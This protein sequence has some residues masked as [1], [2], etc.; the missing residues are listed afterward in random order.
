MHL[1]LYTMN[2]KMSSLLK[3]MN[4]TFSFIVRQTRDAPNFYRFLKASVAR[5][6]H[7]LVDHTKFSSSRNEFPLGIFY[8]TVSD[9]K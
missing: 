2:T 3:E 1:S 8:T 5:F 4:D 6:A 9:V 7:N